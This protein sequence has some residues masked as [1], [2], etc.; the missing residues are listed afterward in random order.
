MVSYCT[1]YSI[2]LKPASCLTEKR[3]QIILHFLNKLKSNNNSQ[4]NNIR[5]QNRSYY[6]I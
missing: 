3:R 5:L 4:S 2:L 6:A 1:P